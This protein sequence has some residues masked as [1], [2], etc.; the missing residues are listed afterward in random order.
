MIVIIRVMRKLC[1]CLPPKKKTLSLCALRDKRD[2]EGN[3]GR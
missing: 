3:R 1:R 2:I